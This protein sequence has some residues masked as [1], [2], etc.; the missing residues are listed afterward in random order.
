MLTFGDYLEIKW[1]KHRKN[2]PKYIPKYKTVFKNKLIKISIKGDKI[3]IIN[4]LNHIFL[5]K[6]CFI[7]V[8]INYY[9]LLFLVNFRMLV[10]YHIQ[11]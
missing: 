2:V 3:N 11:I 8:G 6:Y 10:Q 9:Y 4:I 7:L 1:N 5:S